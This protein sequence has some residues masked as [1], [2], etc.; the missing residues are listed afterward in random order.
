MKR[1]MPTLLVAT[2][3]VSTAGVA[4]MSARSSGPGPFAALEDSLLTRMDVPSDWTVQRGPTS[5][6]LASVPSYLACLAPDAN[7][8]GPVVS[9]VRF[10]SKSGMRLE[11]AVGDSPTNSAAQAM[12][13]MKLERRFPRICTAAPNRRFG[14]AIYRLPFTLGI[15]WVGARPVQISAPVAASLNG[16]LTSGG[17]RAG[18]QIWYQ[19][20]LW[21]RGKYVF[22]VLGGTRSDPPPIGIL[23]AV[24]SKL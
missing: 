15:G 18:D 12:R 3:A 13:Q 8:F 2:L 1:W 5:M 4:V 24:I 22:V 21:H 16:V 17:L 19:Y 9:E 10:W 11:E 7:L 23:H 6:V 14:G 20:A